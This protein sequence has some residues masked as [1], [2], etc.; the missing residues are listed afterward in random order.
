MVLYHLR[1]P[2]GVWREADDPVEHGAPEAGR[3]KTVGQA[4]Q[5]GR[6]RK[7]PLQH[8]RSLVGHTGI[9]KMECFYYSDFWRGLQSC[10]AG[11]AALSAAQTP[12]AGSVF[13]SGPGDSCGLTADASRL[14]PLF[15]STLSRA[16][17]WQG[18]RKQDILWGA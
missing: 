10:K 6:Q 12:T 1:P 15:S 9:D 16:I 8:S 4:Q 18:L 7:R 2:A 14:C 3:H 5:R 13:T 11:T 17:R